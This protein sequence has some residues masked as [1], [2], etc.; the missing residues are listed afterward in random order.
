MRECRECYRAMESMGYGDMQCPVCGHTEY[1]ESEED[2][3]ARMDRMEEEHKNSLD[4]EGI[5]T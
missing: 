4:N 2:F 5:I 1:S 3:D